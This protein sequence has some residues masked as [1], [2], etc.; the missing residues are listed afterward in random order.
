MSDHQFERQVQ[1]K[2]DELKLRPSDS[3]WEGV[4]RDL[5]KNKRRRRSLWWVPALLLICGAGGMIVF[6]TMKNENVNPVTKVSQK[7]LQQKE[8]NSVPANGDKNFKHEIAPKTKAA[9]S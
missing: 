4:E 5:D 7:Q 2:M 3:V 6:Q 9:S 8:R 1:Q